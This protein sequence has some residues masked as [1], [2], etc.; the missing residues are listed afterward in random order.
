MGDNEA[1]SNSSPLRTRCSSK[2]GDDPQ[3][4]TRPFDGSDVVFVV[5]GENIHA[6]KSVL[7]VR[8]I[9]FDII[10][11][12]HDVNMRSQVE[13]GRQYLFPYLFFCGAEV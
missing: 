8:F 10:L 5:D 2:T 9:Q 12:G 6:A 3:D 13:N 4:F 7:K 11:T 1:H